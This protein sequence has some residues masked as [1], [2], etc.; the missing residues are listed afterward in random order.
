M[1]IDMRENGLETGRMARVLIFNI[2]PA[3]STREIGR[4]AKSTAMECS[5]THKVMFTEETGLKAKRVALELWSLLQRLAMKESGRMI[6]SMEKVF[7]SFL[8]AINMMASG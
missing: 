1:G 3:R 4:T 6:K 5:N 8:T 2:L 7:S